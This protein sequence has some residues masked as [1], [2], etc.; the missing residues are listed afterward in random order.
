MTIK[1]TKELIVR[2]IFVILAILL[3]CCLIN[4]WVFS[5]F[6]KQNPNNVSDAKI[7]EILKTNSNVLDFIERNPDFYVKTKEILTKETIIEK[8][9]S[10]DFAPLYTDL[11]L[12]DNRY[13]EIWLMNTEGGEGYATIIDFW[14]LVVSKAYGILLF[15]AQ[16]K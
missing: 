16:A 8:K 2:F 15:K 7:V 11:S 6:Q 9:E 4:Q 14:Q 5:Y 10:K 13:M 3:Y 1:I 12:D